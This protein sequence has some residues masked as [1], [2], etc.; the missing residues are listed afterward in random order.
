MSSLEHNM[1]THRENMDASKKILKAIVNS[2]DGIKVVARNT[3]ELTQSNRD[4][5]MLSEAMAILHIAALVVSFTLMFGRR[6]TIW[7]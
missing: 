4:L 1:R 2:V 6:G 7:N 5:L 3:R